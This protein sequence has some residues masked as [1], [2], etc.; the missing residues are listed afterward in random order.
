MDVEEPLEPLSQ[1]PSHVDS[2]EVADPA[3]QALIPVQ[4]EPEPDHEPEPEPPAPP[5]VLPEPAPSTQP[6]DTIKP[7]PVVQL[8]PVSAQRSDSLPSEFQTW[9]PQ[10]NL[11]DSETRSFIQAEYDVFVCGPD[12]PVMRS[13]PPELYVPHPGYRLVCN[14]VVYR[15]PNLPHLAYTARHKSFMMIRPYVSTIW[16]DPIQQEVVIFQLRPHH[17]VNTTYLFFLDDPE[18]TLKLGLRGMD[19]SSVVWDI[20]RLLNR[21]NAA[22]DIRA[23]IQWLEYLFPIRLLG[24]ALAT[25]A[26][27]YTVIPSFPKNS[28]CDAFLPFYP[29]DPKY[30]DHTSQPD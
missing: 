23:S 24:H 1:D 25:A 30:T 19:V 8:P 2:M 6:P 12:S 27:R 16:G 7:A 18:T 26:R 29:H 17:D 5:V 9:L 20:S 15:K 22:E 14:Q 28:V 4:P 10:L 3:P 13:V 11:H 21:G